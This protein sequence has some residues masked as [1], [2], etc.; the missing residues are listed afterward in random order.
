[1]LSNKYADIAGLSHHKQNDK[2]ETIS[3][4]VKADRTLIGWAPKIN[5]MMLMVQKDA[6]KKERTNS[7]TKHSSARDMS[8]K[9][10]IS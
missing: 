5:E 10:A 3:F 2:K 7:A 4:R 1:M 9:A 6:T 8:N